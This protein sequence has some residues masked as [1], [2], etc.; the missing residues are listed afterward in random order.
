MSVAGVMGLWH[1]RPA[2]DGEARRAA[3]TEA[4]VAGDRLTRNELAWLLAQEAKSAARK[5]R[6]GT[7]PHAAEEAP[8]SH[9][10]TV[11]GVETTLDRLD[12]AVSA[13]ASIHGQAS[14][15]GRR[16]RIDVAALV[17]ELAPEARVE[18]A[19]GAGTDVFGDESELRRMILVLLGQ[20]GHPASGG[21]APVVAVRRE[22]ENVKV[23]VHLGPDIPSTVEP[24]R[25]WLARR[26]TRLGGRL[27]LD[28]ATQTLVLPAETDL[29]EREVAKLEKELA[30]AK[31]QGRAFAREIAS[32]RADLTAKPITSPPAAEDALAVLIAAAR[33]LGPAL[34]GI[35]AAIGRDIAPLRDFEGDALAIGA[36]VGRHV[37]AASELV[38][39]LAR[40]GDCPLHELPRV[41]D[42]AELLREATHRQTSRATRAGVNLLVDVSEPFEATAPAAALLVLFEALVDH[43]VDASP[44]G[45]TVRIGATEGDDEVTVTVDD[46]GP[47]LPERAKVGVLS[48]EYEGLARGRSARL[49]LVAAHAIATHLGSTLV[50]LDAPDGGTRASVTLRRSAGAI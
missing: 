2:A 12:D 10:D 5:L 45:T 19:M 35:L 25:A 20:S 38:S 47:T 46:R 49:S 18:I 4:R 7:S 33:S 27:E 42:V 39:D 44:E 40:L 36:S 8:T 37:T 23:A 31:E 1:H 24:E 16:G 43:A 13:L 15:R 14:P 32:G 21:S 28:G 3:A 17:W 11:A 41:V 29:R 50:L 30:A 9:E 26:A 22:G 48:R 6:S 34:R